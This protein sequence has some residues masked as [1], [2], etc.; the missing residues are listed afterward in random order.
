M[1]GVGALGSMLAEMLVRA[2]LESI[3][4]IDDD[5]IEAGNVNRHV[6][7]LIDVGRD[8][9]PAVAQRLRQISPNVRVTEVNKKLVGDASAIQAQLEKCEIIV[10]CTASDALLSL[11]SNVWFP[12]PRVFVSFSTG[13]AAQRLFSFGVIANR[14][15]VDDFEQCVRPWLV[16]ESEAWAHGDEIFEGAGCWSPLFPARYDDVVLAAATCVK[17][18]EALMTK[19]P[20]GR[21]FR[22]FAQSTDGGFR[23]LI[24]EPVSVGSEEMSS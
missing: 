15:P 20:S 12:I 24:A 3:C 13:F 8:K 4:L 11:L 18:L 16:R 9:V 23:G 5:S 19:R 10:D 14:F 2:G 6:A 1:L 17:E 7:T 22:V 21:Q